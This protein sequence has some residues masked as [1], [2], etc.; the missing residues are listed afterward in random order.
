[1]ANKLFFID[2][3]VILSFFVPYK[4]FCSWLQQTSYCNQMAHIAT[5]IA[6]TLR[7]V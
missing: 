6:L 3:T 5:G 1:M 7:Y 4:K 2:L